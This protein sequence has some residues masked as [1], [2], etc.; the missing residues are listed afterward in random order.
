MRH[1]HFQTTRAF[2][3]LLA[4]LTIFMPMMLL[5]QDG[6]SSAGATRAR[7]LAELG[8]L[9]FKDEIVVEDFINYHRHEI[10]RPRAGQAVAL[11]LRWGANA[12]SPSGEAILQIG[13][14]T[15]LAYDSQQLRPI[16]IALVIDKS[17]S[18]SEAN[19]MTR[20][21]EALLVM[22]E[23]LR[24]QDTIA[25]I[26]F[27]SSAFVLLPSQEVGD[28]T[29]VRKV[30]QD[31]E[32]NNST[33]IHEGLMFGFR[34]VQRNLIRNGTNRVILLTDGIANQGVTDPK[35][36]ASAAKPYNDMGIDL[37]TIGLGQ[38]I[39]REMLQTLA[40]EG[41]GLHH[42]IGDSGDIEKVFLNEVQSLL[43]PAA[44]SPEL[45]ID[46][47]TGWKL[48]HIY[49]YE[50]K[51]DTK[52]AS[53]ELPT[54]NSG[55]TQV[56]LMRLQTMSS[57]GAPV[58]VRLSYFDVERQQQIVIT[59]SIPAP[60]PIHNR[61]SEG[62]PAALVPDLSVTKN[63]AI[64]TLAQGI[65]DMAAAIEEQ[66]FAK[67]EG[68]ITTAMTSIEERYPFDE[69]IL[70]ILLTAQLYKEALKVNSVVRGAQ[71]NI[72]TNGDFSKGNTGFHSGMPYRP[73]AANCLWEH[74]YTIAPQFD[75]PHLHRLLPQEPYSPA[76]RSYTGEQAMY[77]NAGGHKELL[78]WSAVVDCKPNTKYRISFFAMSLNEGPEWL[79]SYSIIVNGKHSAVQQAGIRKYR[80]ITMDWDSGDAKTATIS[81][82]RS[83]MEHNGGLIAISNIQ[84]APVG[85]EDSGD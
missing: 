53:I 37:S 11:D 24:P 46:Y 18:M 60:S 35:E 30:I 57:S 70:R 45:E 76:L 75:Q 78:M 72:I 38:S 58:N 7:Y 54:L 25:I 27:D 63:Y 43:S 66:K 9:P 82:V 55:A 44:R 5:A 2:I 21:K 28:R 74:G 26:A 67:A 84:M 71:H 6:V 62:N 85:I 83:A 40:R 41:R 10:P 65:Y 8:V 50:P 22:L 14:A 64:A 15:V 31:L 61:F 29:A 32:P 39:Q 42:F 52:A 77:A 73:A 16:N 48:Q 3:V 51:L 59:E 17:G 4:L 56:V 49:G 80:L 34:E 68:L 36:I 20:V 1:Q 13:L 23:Q 47:G 12:I 81:I 33:N 79:P 19:K 69:D